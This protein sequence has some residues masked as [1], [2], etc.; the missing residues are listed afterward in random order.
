M[1]VTVNLS[2][3][4]VI[5]VDAPEGVDV[6]VRQ[7]HVE[8]MGEPDFAIEGEHGLY[9]RAWP[10]LCEVCEPSAI[11]PGVLYPQGPDNTRRWV[12]RCDTCARF[13]S[14]DDAA[15][16]LAQQIGGKLAWVV[17]AGLSSPH[18]YID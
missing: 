9:E 3:A 11:V 6:E 5:G 8:S 17:P 13:D 12:E 15:V 1:I 18:P 10:P 14:D 2:S 16:A 4:N 7:Y